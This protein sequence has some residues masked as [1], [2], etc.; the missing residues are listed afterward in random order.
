MTPPS[1]PARSF[2]TNRRAAQKSRAGFTLIETALALG[3][4]AFALVPLV[5]LLPVGI[6]VSKSASD[7][8]IAAQIAQRLTGMVQQTDDASSALRDGSSAL[9]T[10]Y[11]AFDNEGQPVTATTPANPTTPAAAPVYSAA[12]LRFIAANS[13]AASMTDAPKGPGAVTVL[14]QIVSDPGQRMKGKS[15]STELPAD[16]KKHAVVIP[17]FLPDNG[18]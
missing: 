9:M 11:Y 18:S 1:L 16:L 5:G 14:I 15:P 3:I 4:V 13:A 10:S 7:L 6:Q 12:V 17:A 8:T 2:V